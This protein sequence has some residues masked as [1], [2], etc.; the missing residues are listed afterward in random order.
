[1]PAEAAARLDCSLFH[2][3]T[4]ATPYVP[5]LATHLPREVDLRVARL[6]GP[7][8]DQGQV[9]SCAGFAL[10]SVVDNAARRIGRGDVTSPMHV[11]SQYAHSDQNVGAL[12][13][14]TI[15]LD[16]V[17]PYDP[18]RACEFARP[19]DGCGQSLGVTAGD[20][21]RQ[22]WLMG[23]KSRADASGRWRVD[24]FEAMVPVDPAQI[25]LLNAA[26]EAVWL[27]LDID[28]RVW[29]GF[30]DAVLPDWDT[31]TPTAHAVTIIGYRNGPGGREFLLQNSW[32]SSWGRGGVAL[33][34]ESV[35][36]RHVL[37]A[38]RVRVSDAAWPAPPS[39][40]AL[41]PSFLPS[42]PGAPTCGPQTIPTP[43]GC[44]GI[45]S[46]S[47]IGIPSLPSPLPQLGSCAQGSL[48][49]PLTGG[50]VTL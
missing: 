39:L 37:Q 6:T 35:L 27:S 44:L 1:M 15:T 43:L 7:V 13:G 47:A 24:A 28:D 2:E 45:P 31:D 33:L 22:P 16:P 17:W 36:V 46:A 8:K 34:P 11:Y 50:C 25:A 21:E 49:N 32:G 5:G 41:P 40:S 18:R 38:Y 12:V 3:V 42:I 14:R 30:S 20:A 23:E 19:G 10:T 4:G 9:G 26:G 48:P 29:G